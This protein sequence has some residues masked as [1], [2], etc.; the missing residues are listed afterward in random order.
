MTQLDKV[1]VM[2]ELQNKTLTTDLMQVE[3]SDAGRQDEPRQDTAHPGLRNN[4]MVE[5]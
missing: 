2:D 1:I 4:F 5:R 3:H